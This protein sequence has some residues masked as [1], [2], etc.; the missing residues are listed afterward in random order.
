MTSV[1]QAKGRI[2]RLFGSL[3][4]RLPV[5]MRLAGVT[6]IEQANEFLKSYL[7]K[8]NSRFALPVHTTKTVFENGVTVYVNYGETSFTCE[9]G[10]VQ[11][12]GFTVK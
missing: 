6:T 8:F 4:S 2:E 10:T 9:A 7:K 11:P 5:E 12:L 3:Q 1:P